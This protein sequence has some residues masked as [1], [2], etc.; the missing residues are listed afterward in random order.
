MET[1]VLPSPGQYNVGFRIAKFK[2]WLQVVGDGRLVDCDSSGALCEE[3]TQTMRHASCI[4][5]LE[6]S[7]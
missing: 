2:S 4:S 1:R 5:R 3:L 7:H 6:V